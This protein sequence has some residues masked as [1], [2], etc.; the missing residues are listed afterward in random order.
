MDFSVNDA[1]F[2]DEIAYY[3]TIDNGLYQYVDTIKKTWRPSNIVYDFSLL[4]SCDVLSNWVNNGWGLTTQ[5]FHSAPASLTESPL[6]EYAN[7]LQS[8]MIYK[9]TFDLT[10]AVFG[11]L[12]FWAKWDIE[13]GFDLVRVSALSVDDNSETVLCGNYTNFRDGLDQ[14]IYDGVQ[15]DWVQE[16]IDLSDLL[17]T[18]FRLKYEFI[19]DQFVT[20]DGFYLDDLTVNILEPS[21]TFVTAIEKIDE[22]FMLSNPIPN[23]AKETTNIFYSWDYN[24]T[25]QFFLINEIGQTIE[26]RKLNSQTGWIKLDL[27]SMSKG[28]YYYYLQSDENRSEVKR[29]LVY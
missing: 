20:G 23:P 8:T 19:S 17:G 16:R 26:Q 27:A 12:L 1:D 25:I 4:D 5:E 15:E 11:E 10:Q 14:P 3:I 22:S 2:G 18:R 28:V 29:L 7:N 9:D 24:E 6:G 21:D 13:A